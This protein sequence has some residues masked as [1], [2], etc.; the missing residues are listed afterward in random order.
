VEDS[1]NIVSALSEV[2][3]NAAVLNARPENA[4]LEGR[5]VAQAGRLGQ[6]TVA[7]NMAGRGTDIRLGGNAAEFTKVR[8]TKHAQRQFILWSSETYQR[9]TLSLLPTVAAHAR[10]LMLGPLALECPK[11]KLIDFLVDTL[12]AGSESSYTDKWTP[13][14]P[15]LWPCALSDGAVEALREASRVVAARYDV[16]EYARALASVRLSLL[17]VTVCSLVSQADDLPTLDELDELVAVAAE[18]SSVTNKVLRAARDAFAAVKEDFDQDVTEQREQVFVWCTTHLLLKRRDSPPPLP[19][20]MLFRS[21]TLEDC[22][23]LARNVTNRGAS[24]TRCT[25][26]RL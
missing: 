16:C 17:A 13:V 21:R 20:L 23:S 4:A 26:C 19:P 9:L 3:I 12:G 5:L 6:V 25:G 24:T 18:S 22:I 14:D 15:E 10:V 11:L 8:D 1:E 7:T 2:G